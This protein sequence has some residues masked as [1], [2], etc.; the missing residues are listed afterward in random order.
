MWERF[1][2]CGKGFTKEKQ[3]ERFQNSRKGFK[4]II[5]KL[6]RGGKEKEKKAFS[7]SRNL[8]IAIHKFLRSEKK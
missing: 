2:N 4:M 8:F 7:P 5:S 1:L 3:W 6:E